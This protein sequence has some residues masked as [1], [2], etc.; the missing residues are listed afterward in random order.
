MTVTQFV[1]GDIKRTW[2]GEKERETTV[3][4]PDEEIVYAMPPKFRWSSVFAIAEPSI[5]FFRNT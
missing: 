2:Q 5:I 1:I 3:W 4:T